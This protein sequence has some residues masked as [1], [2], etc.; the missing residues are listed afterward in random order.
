MVSQPLAVVLLLGFL[1][2][3]PVSLLTN[4]N[5]LRGGDGW[6]AYDPAPKVVKTEIVDGVP[7]FTVRYPGTV[8]QIVDLPPS[9]AGWYV[10]IVGRGQTVRDPRIGSIT[11]LPYLHASVYA[12]DRRYFLEHWQGQDLRG[13]HA[14]PGEWVTLSGLF[15]VPKGAAAIILRLR[16]ALFKGD[17]V[18]ESEAR[19]TDVRMV[20]FPK[21]SAAR[22]YI[23]TFRKG[24]AHLK[25]RKVGE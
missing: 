14:D 4:G 21:E 18:G 3:A 20:L 23:D 11:G 10:A 9:T 24:G 12:R 7:C 13:R 5:A 25:Q 1:Q 6:N 22:K 16:Q 19:F 2:A 15:L 17:S 8:Q